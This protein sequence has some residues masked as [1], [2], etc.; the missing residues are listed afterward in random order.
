MGRRGV[1]LT[2]ST[3]DFDKI[4]GPQFPYH[5]V[6]WV[7]Q[8]VAMRKQ[9]HGDGIEQG[10]GEGGGGVGAIPYRREV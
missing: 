4:P 3:L 10:D 7:K 5:Q 8:V 1:R 9:H 6:L 2:R